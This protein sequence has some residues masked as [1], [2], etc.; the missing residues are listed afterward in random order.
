MATESR[1]RKRS[2]RFPYAFWSR[3]L[4]GAG[5]AARYGVQ[6]L[7]GLVGGHRYL[8]PAL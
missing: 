2:L 7:G 4:D 6:H 5:Q 8:S 1:W 3:A